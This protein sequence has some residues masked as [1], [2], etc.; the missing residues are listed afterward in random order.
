MDAVDRIFA[1]LKNDP[2]KGIVCS[3]KRGLQLMDLWTAILPDVK[4]LVGQ[5]LAGC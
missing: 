1:Y 5:R 3:D 4:T 2:G